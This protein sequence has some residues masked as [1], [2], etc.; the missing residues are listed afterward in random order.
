[1]ADIMHDI[2]KNKKVNLSKLAPFGFEQQDSCY[3]YDKI[4]SGSGFKLTV[5]I[6][7]KGEISAELV[8]P[9]FEEPYTLHLAD[10]VA[11][12]LSA[13]SKLNIRKRFGK[14]PSNALNRMCSNLSKRR[15]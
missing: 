14:L 5:H 12:T 8:D 13:K 2:F 4:L 3:F 1:M 15:N 11:R 10:C 7:A 9:T 6:T